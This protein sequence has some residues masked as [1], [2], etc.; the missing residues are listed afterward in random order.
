MALHPLAR[1]RE[2]LELGDPALDG[3]VRDQL[4]ADC[5]VEDLPE[6]RERLVDRAVAQRTLDGALLAF[7]DLRGL[8][9]VGLLRGDLR[10]PVAFEERQQVVA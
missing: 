7:A 1:R 9:A 3:V 5:H 6:A 2:L 4:V 8:V 10:E